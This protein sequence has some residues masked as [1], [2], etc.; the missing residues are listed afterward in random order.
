V[1]RSTSGTSDLFASSVTGEPASAPLPAGLRYVQGLITL[2]EEG[3]LVGHIREL[4]LRPFEF[5][6]YQGLR[7]TH[8]FGYRYDYTR[9]AVLHADPMPGFLEPLR[10]K[11]AL[12]A[13]CAPREFAQAL[14]TEY[15]PGAPIGWHR[16]K[17]EFGHVVGVSLLSGCVLRFRHRRPDGKWYRYRLRLQPRSAYLLSGESRTQ[18]EH[19]IAPMAELRYSVTFRTLITRGN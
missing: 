4:Q 2:A 11:V 6:G 13:G 17:P 8:S 19:S 16:D 9:Q 12:F 18:W 14:V 15:R 1:E 3:E 10:G 7:R 5:H